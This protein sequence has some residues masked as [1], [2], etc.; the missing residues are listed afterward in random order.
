M[1]RLGLEVIRNG[2]EDIL[3]DLGYSCCR[4]AKSF[5]PLATLPA[6]MVPLVTG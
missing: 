3:A 5:L 4:G 1:H 2:A 6:A